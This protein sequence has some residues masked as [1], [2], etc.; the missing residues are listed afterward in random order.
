MALYAADGIE[1]ALLRRRP[2]YQASDVARRLLQ[3]WGG[4][5][6]RRLAARHTSSLGLALRVAYGAALGVLSSRGSSR[7][8]ARAA[9]CRGVPIF[10]FELVAM[11]AFGATPP[12]RTWTRAEA[13]M[14]LFHTLV[15]GAVVQVVLRRPRT[16][17][18]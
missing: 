6:G 4:D 16:A 11:P 2:V 3:R 8:T 1:R 15:Y 9:L 18:A 5:V 13:A 17:P 12:V 7:S 14:L 10:A